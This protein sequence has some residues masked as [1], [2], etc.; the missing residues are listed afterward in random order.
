MLNTTIA[1]VCQQIQRSEQRRDQ[2]F[3]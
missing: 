2:D 3:Y 1:V